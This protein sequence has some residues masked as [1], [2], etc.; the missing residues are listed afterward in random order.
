MHLTRKELGWAVLILGVSLIDDLSALAA[1]YCDNLCHNR[2]ASKE[3][4]MSN[5]ILFGGYTCTYCAG[6][7][8]NVWCLESGDGGGVCQTVYGIGGNPILINFQWYST[9]R[10]ICTC[11]NAA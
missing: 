5:C 11:G 8:A 9:C 3:C 2:Q 7:P 1:P 4:G 10:G 6:S